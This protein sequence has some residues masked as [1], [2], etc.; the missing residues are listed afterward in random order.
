[1]E[2]DFGW[3]AYKIE[4]H[5]FFQK[6]TYDVEVHESEPEISAVAVGSAR[7][8][9]LGSALSS[10]CTSVSCDMKEPS[11]GDILFGQWMFEL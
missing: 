9:R 2:P 10:V 3:F 8:N 1:M 6:A 7:A 4:G 5:L 11:K